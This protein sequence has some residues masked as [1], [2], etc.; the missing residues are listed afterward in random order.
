[1]VVA[2]GLESD[3]DGAI[4]AVKVLGKAPELDSGVGK[5][6]ALARFPAWRFDKNFMTQLGN[7][8]GY[9]NCGRLRRLRK[10]HGWFVS[11]G[12]VGIRSA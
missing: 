5:N 2:G 1:M 6:Q 7:I 11:R 3:P 4:E 9:Q 10:G 12:E 8:D